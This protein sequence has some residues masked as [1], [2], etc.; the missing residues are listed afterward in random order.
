M[1]TLLIKWLKENFIPSVQ[2]Y[3]IQKLDFKLILL[4]QTTSGHLDSIDDI[5]PNVLFM[6]QNTAFLTHPFDPDI[7]VRFHSIKFG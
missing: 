2:A 5:R 4:I 7:I 6:T 1:A 3:L